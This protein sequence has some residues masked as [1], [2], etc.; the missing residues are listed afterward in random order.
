[1]KL[2]LRTADNVLTR[3]IGQALAALL[4]GIYFSGPHLMSA[5]PLS[6]PIAFDTFRFRLR[7]Q[8]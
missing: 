5:S 4:C 2:L 8:H 7:S 6:A 1:M 3:Q